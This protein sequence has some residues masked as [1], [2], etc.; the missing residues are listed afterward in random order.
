MSYG[1]SGQVCQTVKKGYLELFPEISDVSEANLVYSML[2]AVKSA[3][4][5]GIEMFE[6]GGKNEI[7][8]QIVR[9][10]LPKWIV[11]LQDH[12]DSKIYEQS[13]QILNTFFDSEP[14]NDEDISN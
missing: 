5:K 6:N 1:N 8:S 9:G 14:N 4:I 12:P 7:M 2:I 13:Y 3:I 10:P 11:S